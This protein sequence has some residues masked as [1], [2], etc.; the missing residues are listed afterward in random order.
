MHENKLANLIF[1]LIDIILINS[2]IIKL[3][4]SI[5]HEIDCFKQFEFVVESQCDELKL[6]IAW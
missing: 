2:Q 3:I 1:Q 6:T 4:L 5:T